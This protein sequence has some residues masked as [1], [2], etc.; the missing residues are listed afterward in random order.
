MQQKPKLK[1]WKFVIGGAL[2]VGIIAYMV[3]SGV[4]DTRMY[5]LTPSEITE[6]KEEAYTGTLRLGGIVVNGS[7]KWDAKNLLLT[8]QVADGKAAIPVHYQGVVPD[9]FENGIEIVV[10][11]S[12]SPE[13]RFEATTLM[14]KCPSKYEPAG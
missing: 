2:I 8:F 9:T 14:P 11:G 10:E 13:G 5:Y 4:R 7:I 6:M 3:Y 1:K 12:Y